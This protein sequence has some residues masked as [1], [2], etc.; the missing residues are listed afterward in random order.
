MPRKK[1]SVI[2]LK[3][4]LKSLKMVLYSYK[5]NQSRLRDNLTRFPNN[6][7]HLSYNYRKINHPTSKET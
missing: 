2:S 5:T 7:Y 3:L 6:P 1:F 4:K